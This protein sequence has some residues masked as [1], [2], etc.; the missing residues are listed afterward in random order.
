LGGILREDARLEWL[1][2]PLQHSLG[3]SDESGSDLPSSVGSM[4]SC[5]L[6]N[7]RER[8]APS[9]TNAKGMAALGFLSATMGL[10]GIIGKRV[11][12]PMNT[13]V[14]LTTTWVELFNDPLLFALKGIPSRDIRALGVFGVFL[15][16]FFSRAILATRCGQAGAIGVLAALRLIQMVWWAVVKSPAPKPPA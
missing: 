6:T 5:R 12:S 7:T 8:A 9:W 11:G 15:G 4:G 13:T 2:S 1:C 16:A 3:S 14:V 10:Q